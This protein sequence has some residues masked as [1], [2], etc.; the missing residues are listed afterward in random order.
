M[1]SSYPIDFDDKIPLD[2]LVRDPPS[3]PVHR[4]GTQP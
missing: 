2:A 1:I 4:G 3:A